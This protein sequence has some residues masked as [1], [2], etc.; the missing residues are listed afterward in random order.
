VKRT[1][2]FVV[3]LLAFA[4]AAATAA[5]RVSTARGP[6][7]APPELVGAKVAWQEQRCLTGCGAIECNGSQAYA[8]R[9]GEVGRKPRTLFTRTLTCS[10]SGPNGFYQSAAAAVSATRLAIGTSSTTSA[11]AEADPSPVKPRLRAGP[12][13]GPLAELYNCS[14]ESSTY[15]SFEF[16]LDGDALAYDSDPCGESRRYVVRDL[17]TGSDHPV[18]QPALS[19]VY[20]P[21]L[22]G[23]YFAFLR[24]PFTLVVYD[25]MAGTEAYKLVLPPNQYPQSLDVQPDGKVAVLTRNPDESTNT[26]SSERLS[27]LSPAEPR[28][29][30]LPALPCQTGVRLGAD[31]VVFEAGLPGRRS[32]EAVGLGGG[33]PRALARFGAVRSSGFD[34]DGSRAAYALRTCGG[35]QAIYLQSLSDKAFSAGSKSCPTSVSTRV[36]S[37]HGTAKV[38]LNCPRACTGAARLSRGR[39]HLTSSKAFGSERRG[40]KV[41]PLKLTRSARALLRRHGSVAVKVSVTVTDRDQRTRTVSRRARLSGS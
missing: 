27:W 7:A 24:S 33:P 26:C 38:T 30:E 1:L 35:G 3:A 18:P 36:H 20:S 34:S 17:A 41:L 21:R 14:T 23:R 5:Q 15:G 32:L 11:E 8:L 31:S 4:P 12:L 9:L 29:H 25:W 10:A 28:L 6:L 22:A 37:S 2:L 16:V 13:G 40:H 39:A 19:S